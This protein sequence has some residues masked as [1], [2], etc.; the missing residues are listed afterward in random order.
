MNRGRQRA[1]LSAALL[2]VLT[3][4]WFF[5]APVQLAGFT[6]YA[7]T[8]G[9]S[10]APRFHAGD[11][12]AVR[13]AHSYHVGQVVLYESPVL[14]RPV[15][16][17]I[18]A[19]QNGH[20]FFKGDNNGF[21][22]A[23]YA[24]RGEL[25]GRLWFRV[26][27]AGRVLTWIGTPAHTALIAAAGTILVLLIGGRG[28]APGLRRRRRK[29]RS[30]ERGGRRKRGLTVPA[31]SLFRRPRRSLLSLL[32]LIMLV[33]GFTAVVTGLARPA[34]RTARVASYQSSGSFSYA[35]RASHAADAAYPAGIVR[36]GAPVFLAA[37]HRLRVSFAY[38]FRSALPHDVRGKIAFRALLV[39]EASTWRH[40]YRLG[41]PQSFTGDHVAVSARVDLRNLTDTVERLAASSGT[42][43]TSYDVQLVPVVRITGTVSGKRVSQTFAPTLPFTLTTTVLKLAISPPATLPGATYAVPSAASQLAMALHP[44]QSGTL[45]KRVPDPLQLAGYHFTDSALGIGGTMLILVGA[46]ALVA[47]QV[48]RRREI[49]SLE[50]RIAHRYGRELFDVADL[51]QVPPNTAVTAV[52]DF[53]SLARIARQ[54]ERP[55]LRHVNENVAVFVVDDPPRLY[56]LECPAHSPVASGSGVSSRP[57]LPAISRRAMGTAGLMVALALAVAISSETFTSGNVVPTSSA[58]RST[59]SRTLAQLLPALCAG[60]TPTDLIVATGPTTN[61]TPQNDLI[62]GRNASG[63]Q[64][65]NGAGGTDCLVAGGGAGTTNNFQGGPGPGDVCIGASGATNNYTGCETTGTS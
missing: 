8:V 18:I 14:H 43:A 2:L 56:R 9:T 12:A 39:D 10:M 40:L 4:G 19:I 32:G 34:T 33:A 42:P 62:L 26:P 17:R 65:L 30:G 58:G 11:L 7:A 46:W 50:R 52:P 45:P 3:A 64:T 60:T 29:A 48:R 1:A 27:K 13:R 51:Q 57:R 23:G 55:I 20:Y 41:Q 38:K 53:E 21:V 47:G 15:L 22:D 54:A 16:H 28:V 6:S 37:V 61:G 31:S 5:L 24:T 63:A 35:G 49:W 36:T 25:V 44:S 59:V